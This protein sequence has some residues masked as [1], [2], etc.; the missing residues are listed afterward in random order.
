[1]NRK[2]AFRP[3]EHP[4]GVSE[5]SLSEGERE[6]AASMRIIARALIG[7]DG[8]DRNAARRIVDGCAAPSDFGRFQQRVRSEAAKIPGGRS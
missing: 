1:M 4:K 3:G 8:E 5:S 2:Q 6:S 7:A